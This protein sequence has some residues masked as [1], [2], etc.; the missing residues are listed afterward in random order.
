[1][2]GDKI[3]RQPYDDSLAR[4]YL[5][6]QAFQPTW[7][8]SQVFHFEPDWLVPWSTLRDWI[9]RRVNDWLERLDRSLSVEDY[10]AL[11]LISCDG[12][13]SSLKAALRSGADGLV[14][15]VIGGR[16]GDPAVGNPRSSD[17]PTDM[18][19]I[20]EFCGSVPLR[21]LLELH[22]ER[23]IG[24][25]ADFINDNEL[26]A[27]APVTAV[28]LAWLSKLKALAPQSWVIVQIASPSQDPLALAKECRA[29]GVLPRWENLPNG[30]DY[31]TPAWI[32]RVHE[33]GLSVTGWPL[34]R[35]ED[36]RVLEGQRLDSVW[37]KAR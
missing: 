30:L 10:R 35:A 20:F 22:D 13:P 36:V 12:T 14:L 4:S 24:A 25:L 31:L 26:Y 8:F 2:F 1:M 28:N 34:R 18:Q 19:S 7:E 32:E 17:E 6:S 23:C 15:P 21:A 5:A 37:M 9:P 27:M 29:S 33:A 11:R 16:G 3:R